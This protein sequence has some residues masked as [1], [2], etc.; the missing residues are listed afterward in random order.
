M[1]DPE[2]YKEDGD[3]LDQ[4]HFIINKEDVDENDDD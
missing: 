3:P 4:T 1:T 2:I